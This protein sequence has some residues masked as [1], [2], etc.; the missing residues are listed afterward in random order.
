MSNICDI[1][2]EDKK[3]KEDF[4]RLKLK[5]EGYYKLIK[6]KEEIEE[7]ENRIENM[8]HMIY[9]ELRSF[10]FKLLG[11]KRVS[12]G[13]KITTRANSV[14]V[15][16][17]S[18]KASI[19]QILDINKEL[20]LREVSNDK[21]KEKLITLLDYLYEKKS[22]L[23]RGLKDIIYTKE[24]EGKNNLKYTFRGRVYI[25]KN[26]SGGSKNDDIIYAEDIL[27]S[28]QETAKIVK[29]GDNV[30]SLFDK[31]INDRLKFKI[32]IRNIIINMYEIMEVGEK[33]ETSE[34]YK[35]EGD[36]YDN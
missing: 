4:W 24:I 10:I 21:G 25:R 32:M 7:I 13:S 9:S 34:L 5:E 3:R 16:N 29:H 31:I 11:E 1:I 20:I 30:E 33:T 18:Q 27:S 28:D 36:Y 15:Y 23:T 14:F 35:V 19:R 12:I 6:M 22:I 26:E 17:S 8:R 2:E